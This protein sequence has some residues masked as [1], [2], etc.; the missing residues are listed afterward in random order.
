MK[1]AE[2]SRNRNCGSGHVLQQSVQRIGGPFVLSADE[3]RVAIVPLQLRQA[4]AQRTG[5]YQAAFLCGS[6]QFKQGRKRLRRLPLNLQCDASSP[7]SCF[8]CRPM[9]R[10]CTTDEP[11]STVQP[12]DPAGELSQ[13]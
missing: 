8:P 1:P 12:Q 9:R 5:Q 10:L 2:E 13:R 7:C 3:L 4:V 6:L 11:K